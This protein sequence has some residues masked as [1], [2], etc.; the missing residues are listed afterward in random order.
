M[1]L[2]LECDQP[3]DFADWEDASNAQFDQF[4]DDWV[5]MAKIQSAAIEPITWHK[6]RRALV[7]AIAKERQ[8]TRTIRDAQ[9]LTRLEDNWDGEGS[10]GFSLGTW[11]RVEHFLL[12]HANVAE[13]TF[14][15]ALPVPR[16]NPADEG[17]FDVFWKLSERHLLVNFPGDANSPIT[18]YGQTSHGD[19]TIAG[20]TTP[21]QPRPDLI[22]WLIQGMR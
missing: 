11:Q 7:A 2:T 10:K 4:A 15:V 20:R 14:H 1:P 16:I 17:S 21:D 5:M 19:N 12:K 22:A 9:A 8:L 13:T 18:Y 3:P 6:A